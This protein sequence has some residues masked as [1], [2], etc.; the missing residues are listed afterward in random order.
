M[1]RILFTVALLAA[2]L[3][4]AA[5]SA[6]N[7]HRANSLYALPAV[8]SGDIVFIGN[9]ITNLHN[10]NEA[11]PGAN[12]HNRGVSGALTD[13]VVNNLRA[14]TEGQPAKI[15]LMIGTNDL[16]TDGLIST[17]YVS[18]QMAAIIDSVTAICPQSQLYVQ[19]ILPSKSGNRTLSNLSEANS[20]IKKHIEDLGN[21]R[22][23][24]IDLY[25]L[26]ANI[27]DNK[28]G[29]SKDGLHLSA[30]A[31]S[32][33]CHAIEQYVGT[34]TAYPQPADVAM[35]DG[36]LPATKGMRTTMFANMPVN[37][38]DAIIIGDELVCGGEW[39]ELLGTNTV[40]NRGIG[41]W[42]PT[43]T[44]SDMQAALNA[45][46]HDNAQP[47]SVFVY[48][49]TSELNGNASAE[50]TL[51]SYKNLIGGIKQRAPKAQIYVM[52]VIPNTN[53]NTN[54]NKYQP[55]N[56][57]LKAWAETEANVT[58]ID[59]YTPFL[60]NG[61]ASD[62]YVASNYLLGRGYA[63]MAEL[64]SPYIPGSKAVSEAEATAH[65]AK[66]VADMQVAFRPKASTDREQHCYTFCSTLRGYHFTTENPNGKLYGAA[67]TGDK[68]QHWKFI[69]RDD[70]TY[71]IQNAAT[72]NY[73]A[74]TAAYNQQITTSAEK[75]SA[76]WTVAN[77]STPGMFIV[78]SDKVQLNQTSL[79]GLP[80]YNW[81]TG[82]TGND[83]TD[84][85]CQIAIREVAADAA[86]AI[87]SLSMDEEGRGNAKGAAQARYNLAGQRVSNTYAGIVIQGGHKL[88]ARP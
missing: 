24:Y 15:F 38:G 83:T 32:A 42:Y 51:T 67:W 22:V 63:K 79:G 34:P 54:T 31:Y 35:T 10:W 80:V 47:A 6:F 82:N 59:T 37:S 21:S 75:P 88:V 56:N 19:S 74:P 2:T 61:K 27:A 85:G 11:F 78:S 65:I 23:R 16:G 57:Q 1:K 3:T 28:D 55:F 8:A 18:D 52:A 66:R 7:L 45:I 9:S 33:W 70:G 76:G 53:A 86:D 43:A 62:T 26:L 72:G 71:D 58:F 44:I 69:P 4:M 48:A 50:A 81:S 46:F 13:E 29:Y 36:G 87:A 84:M 17:Q 49:G 77:A 20:L 12:V 5:Q 39:Q 41:W 60:S 73:I 30:K 68:A 64:L 25:D 40:K 14:Y